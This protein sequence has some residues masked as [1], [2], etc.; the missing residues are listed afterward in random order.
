[1]SK[2]SDFYFKHRFLFFL[3]FI[4]L[5]SH[6]YLFFDLKILNYGDWSYYSNSQLGM[7]KNYSMYISPEGFG[8]Q[9]VFP[10]N[11]IFYLMYYIL[12]LI[13]L[14]WDISTRILFLLP[15][16][17]LTPVF[18]YLL[19]FKISR[20]NIIAFAS[21]SLYS[22]N[23]FFL[24]LQLDHITYAFLWWILP[25]L[26]LSTL[27]FVE[28]KNKRY[29]V[30]NALLV[31]IAIVYEIRVAI[32]IIVF[33]FLFQ[34]FYLIFNKGNAK[35]KIKNSLFL[36]FSYIFGILFHLYWIIPVFKQINSPNS[37]MSF[38]SDEV[39]V[40]FYDI[41]DSMTIHQYSW[42]NNYVLEP[43]VKQ[44]IELRYFLI[45]LFFLLGII[46]FDNLKIYK[47]I[48]NFFLFFLLILL[49][50]IFLGKQQNSPLG[51]VYIWL[52]NNVPFFNLYRESS[53]FFILIAISAAFFFG[54]GLKEFA[55]KFSKKSKTFSI[56]LIIGV[57][58]LTSFNNLEHF[59]DQKIG[60]MT[61]GVSIPNDY[62]KFEE[63]I[64]KD[65]EF[66]RILWVPAKSRWGYFSELH[67]YI[68][69]VYSNSTNWKNIDDNDDAN[70]KS[71]LYHLNENY[72][73]NL[74]DV[75]SIKYVVIPIDSPESNDSFFKYYDKRGVFIDNISNLK[76]LHKANLNME[77][78]LVFEN[79][80]YK[81]HIYLT[82][83]LENIFKD[84]GV[85]EIEFY[86]E[87]PVK[88]K[89]ILK[90]L[91][92]KKFLN[93]SE[94]FDFNWKI[95][96][97]EFKWWSGFFDKNF[98]LPEDLHLKNNA[99]LNSYIIDPVFIKENIPKDNYILNGDGSINMEITLFYYP[100]AYFYIGLLLTFIILLV[101]IIC[102]FIFRFKKKR[103]RK[104]I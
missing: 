16:V 79:L 102:F 76:Y 103:I 53:K 61:K 57:L 23:T 19:F 47:K 46:Y 80:D 94:A 15:I 41:L 56:I 58:F 37:I 38:A 89:I 93:F 28:T 50:S 72:S 54:I 84:T 65:K 35:T 43:F 81:P 13:K 66:N 62:N 78:L 104:L 86:Q 92:S 24:K 87:S 5:I 71:I 52:F 6:W 10:N 82:K 95:R 11:W 20:N 17:V 27:C 45:P 67:P 18:S 4:S 8:T 12:G 75:S 96:I 60:Q 68:S 51:N 31:F 44:P 3:I 83:E 101:L 1:M 73:D 33:L 7:L 32:I 90:N 34:I 69:L 64:I 48:K 25:A 74:L 70:E 39:F 2:I 63:Y 97:G 99:N 88:Y 42:Y 91:N 40:P 77:E 98:Y 30:F 59:F 9:M 26:L 22:F 85:E 100:Q 29:L 55:K 49:I 21:A 36:F 14:S